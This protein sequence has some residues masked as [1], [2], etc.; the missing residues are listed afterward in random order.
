MRAGEELQTQNNQLQLIYFNGVISYQS[1]IDHGFIVCIPN[2]D[3]S[4][5]ETDPESHH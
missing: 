3:L 2:P 5:A 1:L 4:I